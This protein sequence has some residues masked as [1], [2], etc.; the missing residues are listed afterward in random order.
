MSQLRTPDPGPPG[1]S[2]PALPLTRGAI[3][4]QARQA[5]GHR[6]RQT[7]SMLRA[8]CPVMGPNA[9]TP[10]QSLPLPSGPYNPPRQRAPPSPGPVDAH[11]AEFGRPSRRNPTLARA[12]CSDTT[13]VSHLRFAAMCPDA[14]APTPRATVWWSSVSDA[15]EHEKSRCKGRRPN[16][17]L[18]DNPEVGAALKYSMPLSPASRVPSCRSSI[19][20]PPPHVA[21]DACV[22]THNPPFCLRDIGDRLATPPSSELAYIGLRKHGRQDAPRGRPRRCGRPGQGH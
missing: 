18:S 2:C 6:A 16:R 17:A 19:T 8:A 9:K 13:P 12:P 10:L 3:A 15:E 14:Y 21:S 22:L 11:P 1:S 4:S 20:L 7:R 5:S